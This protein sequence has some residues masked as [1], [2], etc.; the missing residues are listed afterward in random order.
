MSLETR[1]KFVMDT[2]KSKFNSLLS[3]NDLGNQSGVVVVDYNSGSVQQ[4]NSTAAITDLSITNW[5]ASGSK[6]QLILFIT[7]SSDLPITFTGVTAW[8]SGPAPTLK[9]G[10]NEL[11][12]TTIDG[13]V[14]V[15]GHSVATGV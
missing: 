12:F 2:I 4:L 11:V 8:A 6:G 13:G 9:T 3:V 7:M 1:I 10:L 15:I 14:K 5:P